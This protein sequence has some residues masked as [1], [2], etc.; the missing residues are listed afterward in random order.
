MPSDLP[1]A[2]SLN[3]TQLVERLAEMSALG[4]DALLDATRD[5]TRAR[6]RF[7][8]RAGVRERVERI[9]AAES[10]CCAFLAF[11]VGDEADTVVL[12][13]EGPDDATPVLDELVAAF[14]T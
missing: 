11:D 13:I 9:A 7:A 6:L 2:C 14:A 4:E 1:I 8:A 10:E 12:T 5:G 3:A